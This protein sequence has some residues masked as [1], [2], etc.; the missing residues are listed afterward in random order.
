VQQRGK[1]PALSAD[2]WEEYRVVVELEQIGEHECEL[3]QDG[4]GGQLFR[5]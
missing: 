2:G 4:R 5:L 3:E 1:R